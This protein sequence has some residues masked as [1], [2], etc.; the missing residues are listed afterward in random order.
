M[1][2]DISPNIVHF[3]KDN[4]IELAYNRFRKI[5]RD[6]VLIGSSKKIKGGQPCVCFSEAPLIN[7]KSGLVN[8][9]YYSKYSPFGFLFN[10]I[11]IYSLGGR[12]VIYQPDTEYYWLPEA[13]QWRHGR[14][15][16]HLERPIDFAWEREWRL[17]T[18]KLNIHPSYTHLV[19]PDQSWV[20]RL[21]RD[22]HFDEM[23]KIQQYS[24]IFRTEIAHQYF[25]QFHWHIWTL[26]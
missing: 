11:Y 3:T 25:E 14:Y 22:H 2:T 19:L 7:L 10:K 23:N 18:N 6:R 20:N 24:L 1:R 12:P 4:T 13:M 21:H 9:N 15:E 5:I 17:P 16:P 26:S 8:E